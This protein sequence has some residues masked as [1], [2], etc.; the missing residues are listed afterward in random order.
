MKR[1]RVIRRES[2]VYEKN[3]HKHKYQCLMISKYKPVNG[4]KIEMTDVW[5]EGQMERR[6]DDGLTEEQSDE[7]NDEFSTVRRT[8]WSIEN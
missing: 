7:R 8:S 5:T 1:L 3:K 6:M 2:Y 4:R